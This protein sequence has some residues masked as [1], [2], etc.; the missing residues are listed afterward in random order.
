MKASATDS[1]KRYFTQLD[2]LR[3]MAI[4]S[5]LLSHWV[6]CA[7]IDA[8]P[9]GEMGVNL[10]F[11]LSGF[12]I[13]RILFIEKDK[14]GGFGKYA[15]KF[16]FRRTLR[17]FPI[18]YILM[19]ALYVIK[20]PLIRE[21]IAYLL[22]YTFNSKCLA[23]PMGY[24]AY[25]W[26]LSVE[27]QFYI[28]FP[29]IIFFTK[30]TKIFIWGL[31]LFGVGFRLVLFIFSP[32][33]SL[34]FLSPSCVDAFG[35]GALLAYYFLY[36][37]DKLKAILNMKYL[38]LIVLIAFVSNFIYLDIHK[39][40]FGT[41][42]PER[43]LFS[44]CC[45]WFIGKAIYGYGGVVK[46]ILENKIIVFL[47]KISYG[48]YLYHGHVFQLLTLYIDPYIITHFHANPKYFPNAAYMENNVFLISLELFAGT[49]II[50]VIS[51]Y[52]IETPIVNLKKRFFLA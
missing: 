31:I 8:I 5:V 42:V 16:Y 12:L 13:T 47:G 34:Y 25:L 6:R 2:G 35:I 48:L 29:F 41:S 46:K 9:F 45:F 24:I 19:I 4:I 40:R 21:N 36:E 14:N 49:L 11:V 52:L 50:S 33:Y 17:I 22:T 10:F 44:L 26:S 32:G 28:V 37:E 7:V 20:F 23:S 39:Y 43:F 30:R 27:E 3:C 51:W 18:Y 1:L 38:F 15:K